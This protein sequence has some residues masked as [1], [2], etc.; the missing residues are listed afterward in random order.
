MAN[1][2]LLASDNFASGSLASGWS[3]L[4]GA[5]KGQVVVGTPNAVEPNA[6]SIQA[7]QIWTGLSWPADQTSEV[8][9]TTVSEAGTTLSLHV[10]F[11]S[12]AYSGYQANISGGAA[13]LYVIVAGTLTQLGSTVTGLTFAAGDVWMFQVAGAC[14]SLYQNGN[15]VAYFY[16]TT[17]TGGGSPGFSQTTTVNIAN[18]KVL[19][20][21]GYNTVQQDGVWKKQGVILAPVIGDLNGVTAGSGIQCWNLF[22]DGNAQLLSGQ[23]YK[24]WIVSNW[25]NDASSAMYYAESTDGIHWTR[26]ASAVLAGVTNGSVFKNGSTYYMYGQASGASGSGNMLVYTSPDGINWTAQSPSQIIGLGPVGAWDHASFYNII[27]VVVVAGTWYGFYN[28]EASTSTP[29]ST[30]LATSTDG[31]NWVKHGTAPVISGVVIGSAIVNVGGTWYT[32]VIEKPPGITGGTALDPFEMVRYSSPDLI[33]WTLSSHSLHRS[34]IYESLNALT[35]GC[36]APA[37]IIDV[38][39]VAWMWINGGPNDA[40]NPEVG[41][42]SLAIAPTSTANLVKFPEDAVAQTASDAFTS[43][44]GNLSPSWV[45]PPG[46]SKLQIAPGN[47]VEASVINTVCGQAYTAAGPLNDQYSEVTVQA[48]GTGQYAQPAVRM[49]T[50]SQS[51]YTCGVTDGQCQISKVVNGTTT[52]LSPLLTVNVTV[53]DVFRLSVV[54]NVISIFQNGLLLLQVE[55]TANSL[56]SGF[57]GMVMYATSLTSAQISLWAGGTPNVLPAYPASAGAASSGVSVY[58][59]TVYLKSKEA[60]GEHI[61][62]QVAAIGAT[63]AAAQ[64]VLVQQFGSDLSQPPFGGVLVCGPAYTTLS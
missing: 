62:M 36:G 57:P 59:F 29:F 43:G 8:T 9:T 61:G 15:R 17:Y 24:T 44:T 30:G 49:S 34:Q 10:R 41:Q 2:Q 45:T 25:T 1:N 48:I 39:G 64:Q 4:F 55:D 52:N 6:T 35:G 42:L 38:G 12:G 37:A 31:I 40:A 28:G 53:G 18:T 26:K 13:A 21:R 5:L 27:Q 58:S 63:P 54:G 19:S 46:L 51:Y 60:H 3:P 32:W 11:Q 22:L 33:N 50:S 56:P 47:L 14:L 7:G 23:V 16:D 20:W